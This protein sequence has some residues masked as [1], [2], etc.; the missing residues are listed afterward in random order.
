MRK[1]EVSY[2]LFALIAGATVGAGI[3]LLFAPQAG[4]Q[5]RSS[6][7]DHLRKAKDEVDQA[8]E[9]GPQSTAMQGAADAVGIRM[10]GGECSVRS[11]RE[12]HT[13][14]DTGHDN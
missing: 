1:E 13:E 11:G 8:S 14:G 4:P 2:T 9:E 5:F 10:P 12:D 7:R 6:V 3:G